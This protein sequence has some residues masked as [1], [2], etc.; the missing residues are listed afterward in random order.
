[1]VICIIS[2]ALLIVKLEKLK[3]EIRRSFNSMRIK[4]QSLLPALLMF[5]VSFAQEGYI[6][7]Q[8][9]HSG[10][11]T[12]VGYTP[13]GKFIITASEDN[14]LILW[15]AET[16]EQLNVFGGHT[17]AVRWFKPLFDSSTIVSTGDDGLYILTDYTSGEVVTAGEI[18]G[19][20]ATSVFVVGG[21]ATLIFITRKGEIFALEA[22]DDEPAG[23]G[24]LPVEAFT[25]IDFNPATERFAV[26][27][28]SGEV[29]IIDAAGLNITTRLSRSTPD[30]FKKLI[31]SPDGRYLAGISENEVIF[32]WDV[33]ARSIVF[34]AKSGS[35]YAGQ[36]KFLNNSRGIL[37]FLDDIKIAAY[38]L[39][40]KSELFSYKPFG[41][42][43]SLAIAP[44][45]KEATTAYFDRSILRWRIPGREVINRFEPVTDK[46][47]S[48]HIDAS[49]N[50]ILF[51]TAS[52][53]FHIWQ[54][55]RPD[56][57]KFLQTWDG[58]V[59]SSDIS[60]S[61]EFFAYGG[62]DDNI[63]IY[64][65]DDATE[66]AV[67]G[68]EQFG[69]VNSMKWCKNENMIASESADHSVVLRNISTGKTEKRF[70]GPTS[71]VTS[72]ALAA[73]KGLIAAGTVVGEVFIWRI[74]DASLVSKSTSP[75]APVIAIGI[76]NDGR[77]VIAAAENGNLLTLDAVS[78]S[79]PKKSVHPMNGITSMAISPD[80]EYLA[81]AGGSNEILISGLKDTS[82]RRSV[83]VSFGPADWM[84]FSGD[85][86]YLLSS[87]TDGSVYIIDVATGNHIGTLTFFE[88]GEW[89][90]A[91]PGNEFDCSEDGF[92]YLRFVE[93]N[94]AGQLSPVDKEKYKPGLADMILF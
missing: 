23:S 45:D 86:R 9:G 87:S 14:T 29:L 6:L 10:T 83:V 18:P 19:G 43:T 4:F 72:I 68:G 90:L 61:G 1:M 91:T 58:L 16:L 53:A 26:A 37:Y 35:G 41:E 28:T 11:I 57:K 50:T 7:P 59:I 34:S 55:D 30:I 78:L 39:V 60:P 82:F 54:K 5:S 20:A 46:V 42:I 24:T 92:R 40:T 89:V 48:I 22:G 79:E 33:K 76:I 52:S 17:A 73:D 62:A 75:G 81:L 93:H 71:M 84:V 63:K 74:S 51:S 12:T 47:R 64:G 2:E 65:T 38:D 15:D 85:S 36:L 44:D 13:D 25:A 67:L 31:F 69:F 49:G 32:V 88:Q 66:I 80:N 8:N 27:D 94:K 21:G 77:E 70:T 3:K 56:Q